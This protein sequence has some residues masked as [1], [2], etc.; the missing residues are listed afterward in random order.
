MGLSYRDRVRAG[1]RIRASDA[2]DQADDLRRAGRVRGSAGIL[3]RSGPG[4]QMFALDVEENT[5]GFLAAAATITG[6]TTTGGTLTLGSGTVTLCSRVGTILTADGLSV[7]VYNAGG[8]MTAPSGGR[9]LGLCWRD[10]DWSV[11]VA[12]CGS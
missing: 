12:K 10:G 4:G 3:T 6:A 7:T 5:Y 8:S 1:D 11:D 9:I 2:N